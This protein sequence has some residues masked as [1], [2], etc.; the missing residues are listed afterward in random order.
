MMK[1][2]DAYVNPLKP[3]A[4]S[5]KALKNLIIVWKQ[6]LKTWGFSEKLDSITNVHWHPHFSAS[7][8]DKNMEQKPFERLHLWQMHEHILKHQ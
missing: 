7:K 2:M 3:K 1:F 5:G 8:G 4:L 6:P